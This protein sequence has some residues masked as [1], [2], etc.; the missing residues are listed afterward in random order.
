ME[1]RTRSTSS[2]RHLLARVDPHWAARPPEEQNE[3]VD[4]YERT[5]RA[6]SRQFAMSFRDPCHDAADVLQEILLKLWVKF[7]PEDAP[8]R[9]LT[10][11]PCIR[12]LREW[13]SL[14]QVDWENAKRRSAKR[15]VPLPDDEV[16]LADRSSPRPDRF[17]EVVDA[18][19]AFR[20]AIRD[21]D[22]R[23]IYLLL[24]T[25]RTPRE[26]AKLTGRKVREIR[27]LKANL[28]ERLEA[29]LR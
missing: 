26:I 20:R 14:D 12:N 15:R 19:G 2:F 7:L 25:G 16:G 21:P 9:L 22:E 29:H 10:E 1:A 11:R 6:I 8:H 13:K 3:W 27:A 5:A 4:W 24:R 17:V 28:R 23:R 18:E